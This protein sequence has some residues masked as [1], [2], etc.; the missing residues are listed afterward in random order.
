M[1][2]GFCWTCYKSQSWTKP[3]DVSRF[4]VESTWPFFLGLKFHRFVFT[5]LSTF[6]K[7]VWMLLGFE[8]KHLWCIVLFP[9]LSITNDCLLTDFW[10]LFIVFNTSSIHFLGCND[11]W[12]INSLYAAFW[13]LWFKVSIFLNVVYDLDFDFVSKFLNVPTC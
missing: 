4:A 12:L 13:W 11:L 8:Q 3:N 7:F 2:V 10:T 6:L 5:P 9:E 1:F